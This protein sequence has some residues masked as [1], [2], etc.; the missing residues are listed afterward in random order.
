M[1]NCN[2]I[3]EDI[4]TTDCGCVRKSADRGCSSIV[5]PVTNNTFSH[6]WGIVEGS[7]FGTVN[8]F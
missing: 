5:I 6:I 1:I 3:T 7:R 8:G 2:C 4:K